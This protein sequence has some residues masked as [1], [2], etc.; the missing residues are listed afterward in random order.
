M[1]AL[2]EADGLD[3]VVCVSL[4][5]LV[6]WREVIDLVRGWDARGV[7]VLYDGC[8]SGDQLDLVGAIGALIADQ[9]LMR[10]AHNQGDDDAAFE[11]ALAERAQQV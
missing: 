10:A 6:G 7:R 2:V 3:V 1:R 4:V 5:A 9:R 8:N 11:Q